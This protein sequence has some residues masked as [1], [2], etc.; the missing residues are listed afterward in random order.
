MSAQAYYIYQNGEQSGPFSFDQLKAAF[1]ASQIGD[2]SYFWHDGL[3]D[4]KP[5]FEIKAE[6]TGNPEDANGERPTHFLFENG[7]QTG[8][9]TISA[10]KARYQAGEVGDSTFYWQEGLETWKPLREIAGEL[11]DAA[12]AAAKAAQTSFTGEQRDAASAYVTIVRASE[13]Y[14]PFRDFVLQDIELFGDGPI[15]PQDEN[16]PFYE[17]LPDGKTPIRLSLGEIRSGWN[18]GALGRDL[19]FRTEGGSDW[20]PLGELQ[21]QMG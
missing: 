6:L 5:L 11:K 19:P 15:N 14:G 18:A 21:A 7:T 20:K 12:A 13:V 2:Q 17:I 9:Y 1:Q 16:P 4:W 3:P 10:L 8:P